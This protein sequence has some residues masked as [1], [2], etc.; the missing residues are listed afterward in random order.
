QELAPAALDRSFIG[1]DQRYVWV[2]EDPA[3]FG[4]YLNVEMQ[5]IGGR[6]FA[7]KEIA[8]LADH[9]ALMH[10]ASADHAVLVEVF[11]EHVQIAE[12]HP[13]VGRVGHN[14]EC[15]FARRPQHDAIARGDHVVLIGLAAV[16]PLDALDAGAR[17]DVL[18]LVAK[19]TRTIADIEV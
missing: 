9:L 7:P 11:R 12:A 19:T 2:D 8:D 4:R 1:G 16:G 14:I 15:D 17:P 13:L 18:A 3:I 6:P 10:H 5:V